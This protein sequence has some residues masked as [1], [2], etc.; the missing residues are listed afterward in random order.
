MDAEEE[1]KDEDGKPIAN[2]SWTLGDS[3][4]GQTIDNMIKARLGLAGSDD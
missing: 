3:E 1:E 4:K 2:L